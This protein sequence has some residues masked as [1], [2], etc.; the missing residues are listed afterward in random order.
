[1][2][3]IEGQLLRIETV[4]NVL[5]LTA[6]TSLPGGQVVSEVS[7]VKM[8]GEPTPGP[9]GVTVSFRRI[10]DQRFDVILHLRNP[11]GREAVGTNGFEFSATGRLLTQTK[12]QTFNV[13]P[14]DTGS[15]A[16]P[17]TSVLVFERQSS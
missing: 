5:V 10:S 7:Q 15:T 16:K 13:A 14:D 3:Q 4:E 9:G 1:M 2:P 17:V 12:T 8:S 11:S 6:E